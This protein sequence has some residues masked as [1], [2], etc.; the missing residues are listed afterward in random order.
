MGGGIIGI[1][2]IV[3]IYKGFRIFFQQLRSWLLFL[4][5][6][7]SLEIVPLILAYLL[8]YQICVNLL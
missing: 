5:Y 1:G 7:C 6:L 4:C 2:K 8:A 3:F